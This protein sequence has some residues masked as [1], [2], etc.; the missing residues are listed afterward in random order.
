MHTEENTEYLVTEE[1]GQSRGNLEYWKNIITEEKKLQKKTWLQIKN[2]TC[3]NAD[4][5]MFLRTCTKDK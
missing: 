2:D 3:L 1:E 5:K 4:N